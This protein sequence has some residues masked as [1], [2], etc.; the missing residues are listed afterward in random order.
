MFGSNYFGS[1]YFKS[2]YFNEA[3]DGNIEYLEVH[4]NGVGMTLV[5]LSR[6]PT[7]NSSQ[8]FSGERVIAEFR[9]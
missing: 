1:N 9:A 6:L 4:F 3:S 7:Y 2:Y 5:S 8:A